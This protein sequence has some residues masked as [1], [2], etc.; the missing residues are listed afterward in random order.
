MQ[1]PLHPSSLIRYSWFGQNR[2]GQ[3]LSGVLYGVDKNSVREQLAQRGIMAQRISP[4][5]EPWHRPVA[6]KHVT[7]F[8]QELGA[9]YDAGVPL[10]RTLDV[11]YNSQRNVYFRGVIQSLRLDIERGE[12][13]HRAMRH[14]PQVFE[15][16]T[17]NLIES[18][19][20][21]GRLSEI[22]TNIVFTQERQQKLRSQIMTA[23]IYPLVV[24]VFSVMVWVLLLIMVV[25][26]FEGVYQRGGKPLPWLTQLLVDGSHFLRDG[27]YWLVIFAFVV[28]GI[29]ARWKNQRWRFLI[30]SIKIKVPVFG[31]LLSTAW[32]AQFTRVFGLLYQSG[33]PLHQALL[34][35]G[36]TI[37]H[38]P[39]QNAIV[40]CIR[41]VLNGHS[42]SLSMAQH[43]VFQMDLV[44]RIQIGEESGMLTQML[45]Q[46]ALYN[47]FLVEQSVKRLSSL[48]EPFM[49][50]LI[51]G[52][53]AV[54]VIA[55][56]MPMFDLGTVVR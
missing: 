2:S 38:V 10:L 18:G 13:L 42:L 8:L 14:H 22:L 54:M 21:A 15:E 26:V 45:A 32:H 23:M 49:I 43:S 37:S 30:D 3:V 56:Y 29:L 24:V 39:M 5:R 28:L 36:R 44:Q 55:L 6:A 1:Q 17:C 53:V 9:L 50:V 7:R 33:V 40:D 31:S 16:L 4:S 11:L 51:G 12:A 46:H 52:M 19:E 48:I 34:I 27:G 25:P 41:S 20:S 47:E 35:S